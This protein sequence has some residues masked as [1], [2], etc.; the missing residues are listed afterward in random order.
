MNE[1]ARGANGAPAT[2]SQHDIRGQQV[3]DGFRRACA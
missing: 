1:L 3:V 2:L